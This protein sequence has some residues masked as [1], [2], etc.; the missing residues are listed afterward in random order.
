M[1]KDL[2]VQIAKQIMGWGVEPHTENQT[3]AHHPH[4]GDHDWL[5]NSENYPHISV[6]GRGQLL[7]FWRKPDVDAVPWSPS[8]NMAQAKEVIAVMFEKLHYSC[9]MVYVHGEQSAAAFYTSSFGALEVIEETMNIKGYG[10]ANS[11][12]EAICKAALAAAPII[13]ETK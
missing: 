13:R 12:E 7:L 8:T 6:L 3:G 10:W 9:R 4:Q 5:S 2:D 1:I 11:L